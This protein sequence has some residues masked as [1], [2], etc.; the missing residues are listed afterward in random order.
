MSIDL[1]WWRQAPP[2]LQDNHETLLSYVLNPQVALHDPEPYVFPRKP[3]EQKLYFA[4]PC[5]ASTVLAPQ[6][7]VQSG[8]IIDY[9]EVPIEDA[10]S[11]ARNSMSLKRAPLPPDKA[12][13]GSAVN[14]PFWPGGFDAPEWK[15]DTLDEDNYDFENNL[16]TVAPGFQNGLEFDD[17]EKEHVIEESVDENVII[18]LL[19]VLDDSDHNYLGL[20]MKETN[21][22]DEKKD[23]ESVNFNA[24]PIDDSLIEPV[25]RPVVIMSDI[26]TVVRS[27]EWAELVDVSKPVNDFETLVPNPAQEYNFT[28]DG[29]QKLAILK[30]EENSHVFVAAHTS[31]GKTVVAEYAIALAKQHKTRSIY[32]SPIKALS[33]Q[34]YRD[35][36]KKFHDVGLITGDIQIDPTAS[37]LIMTTEILRSMLY[38]GSEVTRDLEY[39]IFDEVHYINDLDRG[40]V[41][42]EVLIL[43]PD[44]VSI[45]M[46]SATVPNTMEFANWVGQTKKRKVYVIS[47]LKRPVPLMHYLYTGC[48]GKTK[49]D[50]FLIV[51][52]SQ[53]FLMKGYRD[54]IASKE[55]DTKPAEAAKKDPRR[56]GGKTRISKPN[57]HNQSNKDQN[58]WVGLIDHLEK[59]K[60]LPVV[61]F[62]LSRN[63]CDRN[64]Q[65][66]QSVDLCTTS[67]AYHIQSFFQ[68]CLQKLKPEDRNIPQILTLQHSLKRGIGVHHSGIL[69]ILKEIVEILFQSGFVKLLFATE[70]FAMGVNMP[71]K[72]VIFDSHRKFDGAD[73][74][75]LRA[76][77]YTQ[78]AGRA[79]RRGL[80]TE[81]T[82]ILVC[83][84]EVPPESELRT[85]ILGRPLRLDSKFRLTYA[86]ILN[87]LRV[88]NVTVEDMI[89]HSFLEFDSQ[90]KIPENRAKLME[91]EKEIS[92]M[93][94]IGEHM[95]PLCQFYD[96]TFEYFQLIDELMADNI[97]QQQMM[98]ELKP[99]RVVIVTMDRHYNKIG[100][101]LSIVGS[102]EPKFKVMVLDD[103]GDTNSESPT[104]KK[105]NTNRGELWHRMIS[106]TPQHKLYI[107]EGV[108]GHTI[109]TIKFNNIIEITKTNMKIEADKII[110]NWEQRQIPRFK[111]TPP[112][113]SLSK[114]VTE[115]YN[116]NNSVL[117]G[118]TKLQYCNL[119]QELKTS[120]IMDE[121]AKLKRKLGEIINCTNATNFEQEFPVVFDRKSLEK[122]KDELKFKISKESLLLYPEYVNKLEVLK[123]MGYIDKQHEVKM[124]GRVACEMGS[125]ELITTELVLCNTFT[126]L[127]P[128]EIAALLS[129]LVFQAK[130]E[131]T[132]QLTDN[133]KKCIENIKEVDE[134]IVEIE[135]KHKVSSSDEMT[136]RDRLNFGL[137]EV[138]YEW[139]RN[140]S[141]AE[142]MTLTDIQE[143]IIVRCIQQLN[144]TMQDVKDA[145][146]IIGNPALQKK[147]EDASN[148]IQRNIVFAASLYLQS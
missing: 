50:I 6:R 98:K 92:D 110:Q 15:I 58:L 85:M 19:S 102:R 126:D 101:F 22:N 72:T 68:K 80:D 127:K 75:L 32:T 114:T 146:R 25:E 89:S 9:I 8:A 27:L 109:L 122:K 38:C 1:S 56:G 44:H 121:I 53:E 142:I 66:L 91:A 30:L 41:W 125:N 136:A 78:M 123:E 99:G 21:T 86:M 5:S 65:A 11:N 128:E 16:L 43:L 33:N 14:Y 106:M 49:N 2:I 104:V 69:P 45:V 105:T 3:N 117:C 145:A 119:R 59:H 62:T 52:G 39:V 138:V 133:L 18:N 134:H 112:G 47:T 13:R 141:F 132:P 113:A 88:E 71:A 79:G 124:K 118:D 87:L 115:L 24:V 82:V 139:A 46:L 12:T 94:E 28:L 34:K 10:E 111:D 131:T 130:T 84:N 73:F 20:W 23:S 40:H 100:V 135:N 147:M 81:G 96:L 129:G 64:L 93:Q 107:P 31:A 17:I 4:P 26:D 48:G 70:T 60:K 116:L 37:C 7:D 140:K 42:E 61:A 51:N 90:T 108:G 67:E 76:A 29:F 36:K 63:R 143:G 148:A 137:A 57:T 83:K 144:E 103:L 120:S 55:K 35:F 97:V 77:E 95:Q 54:A 74:R